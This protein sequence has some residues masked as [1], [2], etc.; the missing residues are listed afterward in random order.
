MAS[1]LGRGGRRA[2]VTKI[3]P[4][5]AEVLLLAKLT[6]LRNLRQQT[7]S[8]PAETQIVHQLCPLFWL[9]GRDLRFPGCSLLPIGHRTQHCLY[10]DLLP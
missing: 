9:G 10:L 3:I 8:L 7:A 4:L 6:H 2:T 5:V 1:A